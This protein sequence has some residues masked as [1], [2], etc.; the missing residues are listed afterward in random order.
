M[1]RYLSSYEYLKDKNMEKKK[2][3]TS[4]MRG[5]CNVL[6]GKKNNSFMRRLSDHGK[7]PGFASIKEVIDTIFTTSAL[8]INFDD[9]RIWKLWDAVVGK[10]IA[11]HARPFS[12]KKGILLVMVTDSIWLQELE[13][14]TEGIK[15]RLN[16]KLQRRAIK[17]IRFR[18]GIPG[19]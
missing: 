19:S 18:V 12:I 8:P 13:F 6:L 9:M 16:N 4:L 2:S 14:K 11:E 7:P 1:A 5:P 3:A 15:E 10:K 17:K